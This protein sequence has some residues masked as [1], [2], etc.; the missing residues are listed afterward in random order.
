MTSPDPAAGPPYCRHC[1]EP[2]A[3]RDH[4]DCELAGFH[5]APRFCPQ[6]AATTRLQTTPLGTVAQC[7]DHGQV[8]P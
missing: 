2:E 8:R 6:C 3:A 4:S 1:G 7:A 5:D